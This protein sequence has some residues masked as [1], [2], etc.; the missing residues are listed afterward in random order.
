MKCKPSVMESIQLISQ[1]LW[2]SQILLIFNT[3]CKCL[4][5]LNSFLFSSIMKVLRIYVLYSKISVSSMKPLN[6]IMRT[7]KFLR[8]PQVKT[9]M[10]RC[11]I[12]SQN[13]F[14][15]YWFGET[16]KWLWL[17]DDGFSSRT[18]RRHSAAKMK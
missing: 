3:C 7:A 17:Q 10:N 4:S 8:R 16:E 18:I 1:C 11:H 14:Y 9:F 12:L 15:L 13:C 6:E 5:V 2:E